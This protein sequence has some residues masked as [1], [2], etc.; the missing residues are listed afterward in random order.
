MSGSPK[1]NVD[2][3]DTES[4]TFHSNAVCAALL[5]SGV[6]LSMEGQ[7]SLKL[8]RQIN[9]QHSVTTLKVLDPLL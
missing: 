9:M 4:W 1:V 7:V 2:A 6:G 3:G 5:V 8:E